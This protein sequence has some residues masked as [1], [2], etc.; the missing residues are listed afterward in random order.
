MIPRRDRRVGLIFDDRYL[1]HNSGPY[2]IGYRDPYP[3]AEPVPHLSSPAIALRAKHLLDLFGL[4]DVMQRIP[5]FEADNAMLE[6]YHTREHIARVQEIAKTGGDTGVGAPIGRGGDRIARLAVGG[7]IAGVDAVMR[8]DVHHAYALVRPPGHH[9]VSDRGM[10]FCIFN[11]VAVA[12]R[13]A[14]RVHGVEKVAIVDWDVHHGNGTQDAF[15]DD[16]SVLFISIHQED[17]FP[18]GWGELDQVGD[19]AGEGTTVNIPL[20]AGSGNRAYFAVMDQIVEPVLRQFA[21]DLIMVSAGQDASV[22][23]PLGRM[24]LTTAAYRAMTRQL[25]DI[26]DEICASRLVIALEGGYSDIY[27]PYCSAAIGEGLCEGINGILPVEEPYGPRAES[28]PPSRM[29]GLDSQAAIT[30]A[31]EAH[32]RFWRL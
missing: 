24:S 5:A 7:V 25:R 20:P 27:A 8:Q 16:P 29:I 2:L 11:N 22:Q 1:M 10:G 3:F 26:A 18:V 30:A 6:A 14:Q 4:A 21:P 15:Y 23:D 32:R 17:L 31:L 28:M 13:H 19:D 12:A 9:A